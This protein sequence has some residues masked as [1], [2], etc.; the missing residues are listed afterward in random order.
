MWAGTGGLNQAVTNKTFG[1]GISFGKPPASLNG[2]NTVGDYGVTP[3]V[4]QVNLLAQSASVSASFFTYTSVS[5]QAMVAVDYE[6]A[7]SAP[8]GGGTVQLS[9]SYLG[10]DGV[11]RGVLAQ[12]TTLGTGVAANEISLASTVN[13]TLTGT[14]VVCIMS[15]SNISYVT[16]DSAPGVGTYELHIRVR[17]E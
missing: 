12:N 5:A 3:V 14:A 16:N 17:L 7:T 11:A 4:A 8:A 2:T 15:G 13:Q 10:C 1:T 6:M 9:F